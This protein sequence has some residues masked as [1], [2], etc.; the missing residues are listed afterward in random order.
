MRPVGRPA[1]DKQPESIEFVP[2]RELDRAQQENERLRKEIERLKQETERLRREL[3]AALRAS[4]RQ[5]APHS[6][7]NPR[8]KPKRP[9]R[10]PGC[11]Y[12]RQACRPIPARVDERIA[13][14]LPAHCPHCGGGVESESC[15]TQYQEEI[16][17]RTIVRRFDIAMG[18][19]RECQ[20]R[21]Q[22]RHPLQTSDAVGVGSVQLGPEAL[23]L[24]A[25]L[26]KQMGLSLGHTR[27]VLSYGYGL[28][29][30]RGGLY[31][32][33]A[34]MAG[35]AKPTYDGLVETARQAAVNGMDETGWKVDGRLQWLHV[36]VSAQVTVYAIL[37]GR[38]YAQSVAILGAEYDG[39]LVHDGWA[40][41]YRFR[42]AFHQSCVA[43]LLKR[44]RE[45]ALI[46]SPAAQAFPRAVE[47][48]LQTGLEVRD[49]YERGAISEHGM[50]TATGKL[51]AKLDQM[52]ETRRRNAANHR[53]ARHLEHEL[54]WLFTFLHCP[55]LD[56]TNNA[57]E[58]AIRGMVIAR[59]V[60]G[61]NRTWEG[62]RT[63]EI[64]V[65]VLRTCWQQ[66][67]DAFTR[68][69]R[70]LRAPRTVILDIVP[71]AG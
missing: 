29:V 38:G 67:K 45:M 58:R 63:Q 50:R 66:G 53:L 30:S 51:Q 61:G 20:R 3:E 4:K 27:Q 56:A 36:A 62:A 54:L 37:P 34:R 43:H 55:G 7:G 33:L 22:G 15:E 71:G 18:R 24:A 47:L 69:V 16:V 59:K 35:R 2:K 6:R 42:F 32:A 26:N 70:L 65:S 44:C 60:W 64:L 14:P 41:Y 21:V 8:A 13:V 68:G 10:K 57:A 5:A 1:A 12:G 25:I 11:G 28:E 17:R 52:L 48:L 19:C 46:A 40:P 49:R 31:R 9:G 39:F 23:T